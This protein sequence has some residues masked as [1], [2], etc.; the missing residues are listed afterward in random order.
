MT[1]GTRVCG[2]VE[3]M[4]EHDDLFDAMADGQRRRLLAELLD[5][6][7]KRVPDLTGVSRELAG[8]DEALLHEY[9]AD[10]RA[11]DDAD[12][13][14]LRLHYVHLPKL[15]ENGFV[16]WD[17]DAQRVTRGSRFDELEP[18]LELL[19]RRREELPIR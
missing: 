19:V 6:E 16:D 7:P 4:N 11:V 14:L 12:K 8:A 17:R 13:D 9:L 15:D 3:T 10:D 2:R 1:V 18:F 5:R